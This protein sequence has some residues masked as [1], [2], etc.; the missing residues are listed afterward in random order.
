M[1]IVRSKEF[2][3]G[4]AWGAELIAAIPDATVRLHWTDQPYHWHINDGE[5]VFAVMDGVVD[6]HY[7]ERA[8][9]PGE[10]R[11]EQIV[12]LHAGDLFFAANGDA[13]CAHPRGQARI[14]VIEQS[15]VSSANRT[16]AQR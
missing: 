1:K 8:D 5:E 6:M 7:R 11:G 9:E 4:R 13:H 16:Q 10:D 15:G 14:L 3:A 12:T 2:T